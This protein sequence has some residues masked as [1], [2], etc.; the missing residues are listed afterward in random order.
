[1]RFD[2]QQLE[3]I[4]LHDRFH[5]NCQIDYNSL[6]APFVSVHDPRVSDSSA[7]TI[8]L[9]GKA[10]ARDWFAASY[11][12]WRSRS[13]LDR[14][15]ERRSVTIDFITNPNYRRARSSGFWQMWKRLKDVT[16]GAV[17]WSNVAK[18]GTRRG[19]PNW[20]LVEAEAELA[21]ATLKAEVEQYK[22]R[23]IFF[24]TGYFA[25]YEVVVPFLAA[26]MNTVQNEH[27]IFL[28]RGG[29]KGNPAVLW[30]GHPERKHRDTIERWLK[31]V[32][33]LLR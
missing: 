2:Q 26:S 13:A 19:N 1:M 29:G 20:R 25:R 17:I 10:T 21:I 30:T 27:G 5:R 24:V 28:R 16:G 22:P 23:L 32:R 12:H 3:W 7:P 4:R 8:L 18:I 9:I 33:R 11:E 15:A 31:E 6:A 14:L